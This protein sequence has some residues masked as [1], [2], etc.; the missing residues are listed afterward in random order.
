LFFGCRHPAQD[1]IY[2]SE[3]RAF[4]DAGVTELEVAYSRLDENKKI[5][6]QDKILERKEEV[7]KLIEGGA[8]IYVCGDASRMAPDVRRT[9]AAIYAEKTGTALDAASD[10]IDQMTVEGRYLVDVWAAG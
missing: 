10:W 6:V 1:F 8:V 4:A 3:M 9:F 7:W 2:G 5:Y